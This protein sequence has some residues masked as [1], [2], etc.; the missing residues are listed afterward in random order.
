M[1]LTTHSRLIKFEQEFQGIDLANYYQLKKMPHE[2]T[3][4]KT[5]LQSNHI[6]LTIR[7]QKSVTPQNIRLPLELIR[8]IYGYLLYTLEI[9]TKIEYSIHYPFA[10]PIWYIEKVNHTIPR[11]SYDPFY[12]LDYYIEKIQRHNHL[13]NLLLV[14]GTQWTPAISV[15]K[16]ILLFV[17]RIYHFDEILK[18]M[19]VY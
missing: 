6:L 4:I 8:V 1:E 18:T 16:D 10:P 9:Q 2:S 7:Y 11:A 12:L 15:E 3:S 19:G 17:R 14:Q 5:V 13:Y